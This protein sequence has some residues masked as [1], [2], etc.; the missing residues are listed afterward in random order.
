MPRKK[1][2]ASVSDAPASTS[3]SVLSVALLLSCVAATSVLLRI[4]ALEEPVS[5][6]TAILAL[7]AAF[8]AFMTSLVIAL[9]AYW[10]AARWK[11]AIRAALASLLIA[12]GFVPATLFSFAIENR[13]IEGHV[14]AESITDLTSIEVFWSMFGAMGMF[15]PS[16]LRYLLP[17]PL[18][19]VA[20]AAAVCFYYWPHSGHKTGTER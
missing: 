8:G 1:P 16:G 15:T 13:L 17:W 4:I 10:L 3:G 2:W 12:G 7:V 14:E 5:A 20:L 9:L 11:P 18:L 19:V 6:R